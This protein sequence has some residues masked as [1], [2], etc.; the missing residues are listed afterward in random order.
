MLDIFDLLLQQFSLIHTMLQKIFFFSHANILLSLEGTTQGNPIVMT[1]CALS[2]ITLNN[3]LND[4]NVKQ[5]LYD[6][7]ATA[8]G[9]LPVIFRWW[10]KLCDSSLSYGY[11]ANA[12]K[13]WLVV[14]EQHLNEVKY[15][16]KNYNINITSKGRPHLDA[17]LG[18]EKFTNSYV[19][20]MVTE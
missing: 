11:L 12:D 3:S 1:F 2:T 13:T 20:N 7:D 4:Q 15:S 17:P 8:T 19:S 6:D 16:F 18:N 5:V 14:K 9:S 10:K